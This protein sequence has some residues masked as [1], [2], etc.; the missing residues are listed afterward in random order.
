MREGNEA[1]GYVP[2]P[3][4]APPPR[5]SQANEGTEGAARVLTNAFPCNPF[6]YHNRLIGQFKFRP[7]KHRLLPG[8]P[9][10]R[11]S[12]TMC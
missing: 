3:A 6:Q 5:V 8:Q 11:M 10:V 1:G 12:A 4:G 9:A 7:A 2:A